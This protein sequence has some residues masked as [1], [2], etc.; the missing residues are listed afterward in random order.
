MVL[1]TR[2]EPITDPERLEKAWQQAKATAEIEGAVFT[3][4]DE[5]VI[6]AVASGKMTKEELIKRHK[7]GEANGK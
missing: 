2:G 5:K 1:M 3:A 6:K 7:R 4:E